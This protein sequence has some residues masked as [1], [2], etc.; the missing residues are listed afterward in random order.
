MPPEGKPRIHKKQPEASYGIVKV[1]DYQPGLSK[2]EELTLLLA[3]K[4]DNINIKVIF[5]NIFRVL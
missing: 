3:S 1:P 4:W 2:R 5:Y